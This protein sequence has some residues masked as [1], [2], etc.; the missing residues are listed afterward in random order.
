MG[1]MLK[2]NVGFIRR[3]VQREHQAAMKYNLSLSA[4]NRY[5]YTKVIGLVDVVSMLES[6]L[7]AHRLARQSGVTRHLID[8]TEARNHLSTLQ[9]YHFAYNDMKHPDI[10]R[11]ARVAMLVSPDDHSHDFLETLSRNA[12]RDVT[13]F[14]RREDAERHLGG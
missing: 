8:L 10:D 7:A 2:N 14:T 3:R 11:L 6:V 5:V 9:N 13:L 4:D 1:G 12:G